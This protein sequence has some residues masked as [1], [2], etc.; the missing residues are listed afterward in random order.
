MP[1]PAI[2]WSCKYWAPNNAV[3]LPVFNQSAHCDLWP[4]TSLLRTTAAGWMFSLFETVVC[5][6]VEISVDQQFVNYSDQPIWHQQP[7]WCSL[8]ASAKSSSPS[9]EAWA[10][11]ELFYH[12]KVACE[13][14]SSGFFKSLV[15]DHAS[16][17]LVSARQCSL[18]KLAL[19]LSGHCWC[20]YVEYVAVGLH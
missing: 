4:L 2:L 6:V 16:V 15:C 17:T 11:L 3:G 13:L 19:N 1:S 12:Y 10:E 9:E 5:D 14:K 7:H 8:G 20:W 18:P